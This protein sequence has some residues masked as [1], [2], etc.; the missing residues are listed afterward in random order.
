MKK[1]TAVDFEEIEFNKNIKKAILSI[2]EILSV[3]ASSQISHHIVLGQ[4]YLMQMSS[5]S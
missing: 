4:R 3:F 2:N 5:I 1:S